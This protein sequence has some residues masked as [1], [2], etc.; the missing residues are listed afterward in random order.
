LTGPTNWI[1]VIEYSTNLANWSGLLTLTNTTVTTGFV[2][3][4]ATN[5]A[6]RY[7]RARVV[8]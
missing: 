4:D 1:Y 6:V 8:P 2:D 7:Y 3:T 5:S